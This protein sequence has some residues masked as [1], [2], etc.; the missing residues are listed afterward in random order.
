[1][2]LH[3][4]AD[5]SGVGADLYSRF[6]LLI[7]NITPQHEM[8]VIYFMLHPAYIERMGLGI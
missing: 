4:G 3:G 7:V 8:D 1:M 5:F 6:N 2:L